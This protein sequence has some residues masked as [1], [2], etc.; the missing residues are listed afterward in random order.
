MGVARL[1]LLVD[2][3]R[4][5]RARLAA[6]RDELFD[7][8][9]WRDARALAPLTDDQRAAARELADYGGLVDRDV[10]L[11]SR[12]AMTT[13]IYARRWVRDGPDRRLARR[14]ELALALVLP[15]DAGAMYVAHLPEWLVEVTGGEPDVWRRLDTLSRTWRGSLGALV[16]TARAVGG[17][18]G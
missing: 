12:T 18:R 3:H 15:R 8:T 14:S 1:L 13:T 11:R 7:E 6:L 9:W 2:L 16:D 17:G 4:P 5:E 10:V